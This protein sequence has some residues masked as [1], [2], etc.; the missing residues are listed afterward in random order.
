MGNMASDSKLVFQLRRG[1]ASATLNGAALAEGDA[2]TAFDILA[3]VCRMIPADC[4]LWFGRQDG[5]LHARLYNALDYGSYAPPVEVPATHAQ[6]LYRCIFPPG[7][8][9][10][11]PI[12]ILVNVRV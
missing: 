7:Q 1:R 5:E 10:P 8:E 9:P 6:T 12:R 3:R 11:L 4:M 2:Q